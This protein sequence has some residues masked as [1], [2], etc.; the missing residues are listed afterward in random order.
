MF[1]RPVRIQSQNPVFSRTAC[2]VRKQIK[3]RPGFTPQEDVKSFRTKRQAAMDVAALPKG[4]IIGWVPPTSSA[5]NNSSVTPLSKAAKK[6]AKRKKK[7]EEI[8]ANWEDDDDDE[9]DAG[10]EDGAGSS[11]GGR[12]ADKPNSSGSK[13]VGKGNRE[14]GTAT[15]STDALSQQL[16]KLEVGK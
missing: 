8:R 2:S 13:E 11:A 10:A 16:E 4:H 1:S 9:G 12:A 6:N 5:T 15:T 14:S 7:R 3:I